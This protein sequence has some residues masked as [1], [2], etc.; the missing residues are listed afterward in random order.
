VADALAVREEILVENIKN[1]YLTGEIPKEEKEY[2]LS[3][4]NELSKV[5]HT[6]KTYDQLLP[7][8]KKIVSLAYFLFV[9]TNICVARLWNDVVEPLNEIEK[10]PDNAI[11]I[12]A[13]RIYNPYPSFEEKNEP[14]LND[15][16]FIIT[17]FKEC[18]QYATFSEKIECILNNDTIPVSWASK[19]Y[20]LPFAILKHKNK[21]KLKVLRFEPYFTTFGFRIEGTRFGKKLQKFYKNPNKPLCELKT[22]FEGEFLKGPVITYI[23]CPYFHL[24]KEIKR[25]KGKIITIR[26]ESEKDEK[27]KN[28]AYKEGILRVKKYLKEIRIKKKTQ[29]FENEIQEKIKETYEDTKNIVLWFEKEFIPRGYLK[30]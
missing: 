6:G 9:Q 25:E 19:A 12:F 7:D 26:P 27:V 17:E 5:F 21:E 14:L 16:V 23:Y 4:L 24:E 11:S 2:C 13:Y 8:E 22:D 1:Y 20:F 29:E 18:E 28:Y 3:V 10:L 30:K 15:F